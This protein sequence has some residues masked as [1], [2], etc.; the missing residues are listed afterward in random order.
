MNEVT[1]WSMRYDCLELA[2]REMKYN[3]DGCF[4]NLLAD[5]VIIN[6]E[7]F[8]QFITKKEEV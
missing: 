6:A 4:I 1:R 5:E 3:E 7:K 8:Y 2:R